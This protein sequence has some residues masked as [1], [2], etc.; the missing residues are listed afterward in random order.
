MTGI[1]AGLAALTLGGISSARKSYTLNKM[2][3]ERRDWISSV[4]TVAKTPELE[5]LGFK[6]QYMSSLAD[7]CKSKYSPDHPEAKMDPDAIELLILLKKIADAKAINPYADTVDL[8]QKADE[9]RRV[10]EKRYF[11]NLEDPA[12][13]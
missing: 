5:I 1:I 12:A 7:V 8:E 6:N 9:K 13:K 3:S 4:E 10:L 2:L 11:P